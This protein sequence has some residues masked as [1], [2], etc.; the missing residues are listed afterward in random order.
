MDANLI[1]THIFQ[2]LERLWPPS[3]ECRD[4]E[5]E[6]ERRECYRRHANEFWQ[7]II[8]Q[9]ILGTGMLFPPRILPDF[10]LPDPNPDPIPFGR[11]WGR[12]E[13]PDPMPI[14][15]LAAELLC[16]AVHP[17]TKFAAFLG[18]SRS[19]YPEALKAARSRLENAIKLLD[20]ELKGLESG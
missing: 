9:K 10:R 12:R 1:E 2:V 5:D 3:L 13:D 6:D 15:P 4:I 18:M 7:W 20:E 11:A 16:A 14:H 19:L 8:I 17:G